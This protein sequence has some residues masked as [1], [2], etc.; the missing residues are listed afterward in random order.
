MLYPFY[1]DLTTV[2][3]G[4]MPIAHTTFR[5]ILRLRLKEKR[6]TAAC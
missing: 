2:R 1:E 4:T 6:I 5:V 3:K